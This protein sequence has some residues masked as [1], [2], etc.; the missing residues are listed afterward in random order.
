MS[1]VL[2]IEGLAIA[3]AGE[4]GGT[5]AVRDLSLAVARGETYGLV[6]ESGCGKSTAAL[7]MLGYL[8]PNGRLLAGRLLLE[9]EDL[10]SAS[11]ERL[12]ALRGP[13][14]AMVHQDPI[15]A[16]NPVLTLGRQLLETLRAHRPASEQAMREEAVEMLGRVALAEPASFLARYPHQASGGQLQRIV[17]AMALLARPRLLVL[18]EP[19]TGLDVTVEAEV[20]ALVAGL[21]RDFDMAVVY[22]SHNLGL[23]ASV[24][25][26]IGVM[27]AGELVE[28]GPVREVFARP[29]HPYTRG[30]IACLPRIASVATPARLATI[31]GRVP[32]LDRAPAGCAFAPRCPH[33][34]AA[35]CIDAGPIPLAMA[36]D[37]SGVRCVRVGEFDQAQE[38]VQPRQP[39]TGEVPP[40]LSLRALTKRYERTGGLWA[41]LRAG[42]GAAMPAL[43]GVSFDVGQGEI[44]ALVGESGSGKSTLARVIAGLEQATEGVVLFRDID[45]G[46]LRPRQRPAEVVSAVQL[47]FQNPDRTLNPSHRVARILARA[48][49]RSNRPD[50]RPMAQRVATLLERVSLPAETAAQWPHALSGGQRQ[51]VA[52]ARALAGDPV[53][54]LADEPVSALDVS[55]QGAIINLLLDVRDSSGA[56]M[57]FISHDL[58]LVHA[59]ADRVVVLRHGQVMEAGPRDAVFAAPHHPYTRT[60]LAAAGAAEDAP[61]LPARRAAPQDEGRGCVHAADCRRFIGPVCRREA[62]PE[63][64]AGPGHRIRCHRPI[65][66]LLDTTVITPAVEP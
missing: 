61:T 38:Q 39:R 46:G 10:M 48:L 30:L 32:R 40:R 3:Y 19:T 28:Q 9:G 66:E 44:V 18:D 53:L 59:I 43:A 26:R 21:A 15:G 4:T 62:P 13:G 33:M 60:L 27:Y 22:I 29:R 2:A 36:S 20:A 42:A 45:I 41:R 12:R 35:R 5:L 11:A 58:A 1:Q 55:V 52:I 34:L 37:G 51:R 56:A 25:Q 50:P 14:V 49:R 31:P 64:I 6:G 65:E 16:L 24:C 17:I 47:V 57:L 63:R 23:I 54:V 7:A 8:P